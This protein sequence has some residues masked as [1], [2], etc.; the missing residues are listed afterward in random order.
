VEG[1]G[2]R[3]G[4]HRERRLAPNPGDLDRRLA[5]VELGLAGRVG[6]GD[7]HLLVMAAVQGDGLLDPGDAAGVAVLV[8]EALEDPLRRV[9][10]LGGSVPVGGEDLLDQAEVGSE[11]GLR[12]GLGSPVPRRLGVGQDLLQ[13]LVGDAE[14]PAHGALGGLL[15]EHLAPDLGPLLHVGSHSLS[16]LLGSAAAL[17]GR[18]CGHDRAGPGMSGC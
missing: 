2:E 4:H 9:V 13:G 3:Q 15:D 7:E 8:P 18:A 16:R 10:L 14:L 1:V 12:P 11:P 5:E 6:Q 17:D